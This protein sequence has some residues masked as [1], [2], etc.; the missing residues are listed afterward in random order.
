MSKKRL[1][2]VS[3]VP[4]FKDENGKWVMSH[5]PIPYEKHTTRAGLLWNSINLRCKVG[6]AFQKKRP[7]YIGTTNGFSNFQEFAEWC[8]DQYGYLNKEENGKY[9]AIDKDLTEY[10]N[11][12]YSPDKCLFV[13]NWINTLLTASDAA[14]GEWPL[15]VCWHKQH[16][17]F[18][19]LCRDGKRGQ[20]LGY[21]KDPF[22]AHIAWQ[23]AKI[24][25]MEDAL[26]NDE[27]LRD[28]S[29]LTI[30]VEQNLQRLKDDVHN[31]VETK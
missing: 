8:Q 29:R 31:E 11:L 19:A 9:W 22:E 18:I 1:T 24:K 21:F 17:K 4:D 25:V 13:P 26:V 23:K 20:H 3:N 12:V 28:H 16:K 5:C 10:G 30:I 14:R 2:H 27:E 15:G 7:T 6:G